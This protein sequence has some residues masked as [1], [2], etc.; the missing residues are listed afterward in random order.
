MKLLLDE[1]LSP[2]LVE[3][4]R[5]LY[6]ESDHVHNLKLGAAN[7]S[8]VWDYAKLHVFAIVSKDSDLPNGVL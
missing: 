4:L 5:D 3:S 7:D 1:N 8:E 6:A 2:R